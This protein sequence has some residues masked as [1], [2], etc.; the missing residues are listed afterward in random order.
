MK[1]KR[2]FASLR[3]DSRCGNRPHCT[4]VR[5]TNKG[6]LGDEDLDG[7]RGQSLVVVAVALVVLVLFVAIAVDAS[8]AYVHRR[9]AQNGADAAALAGGRELGAQINQEV[10]NSSLIKADMNSFAEQND[11]PDTTGALA[12]ALNNNVVGYYLD[13]DGG[14]LSDEPIGSPAGDLVLPEA[15]GIE[16][17]TTITA[18]TFFGGIIGLDGMRVHASAAVLLQPP[19]AASCVVPIATYTMTFTSAEGICYNIWNGDGPGNFGWLNWSLQGQECEQGG[20]TCNVPCLE[21]NLTPGT[22]SSGLIHVGDDVAGTTGDKSS[23]LIRSVLD[24]YIDTPV[25]FTV[26]VWDVTNNGQGCG[27]PNGGL[28]YRVAGFAEMQL[29]GYQ[30]SQGQGQIYDPIRDPSTCVTLGDEPHG[31]NRLTAYFI[32]WIEGEPG[33]C[34]AGGSLLAPRLVK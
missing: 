4:A 23:G 17:V 30:L 15:R 8:D 6:R 9:T 32:R 10:Y 34:N 28:Y 14:R 21:E 13:E 29:I 3:P 19:C 20:D 33:D 12:D 24:Y 27:Q 16:A 22:C 26:P 2:F 25:H 1:G 5:M 11:I 7:Q 18:P 31:G